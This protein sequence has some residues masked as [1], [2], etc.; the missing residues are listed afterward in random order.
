MRTTVPPAFDMTFA[1][2]EGPYTILFRPTDEW[3]GVIEVSI[4]DL[5]MRWDVVDADREEVGGLVLGGMTSGSENLWNDQFW[6]ELRLDD[7]PPVIRYWGNQVFWREDR[8]A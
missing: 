4:G 1:G 3:D 5:E 8:V 7:S 2:P 6:F